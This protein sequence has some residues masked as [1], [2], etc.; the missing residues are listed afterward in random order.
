M[1][2]RTPCPRRG[3]VNSAHSVFAISESM[4]NV[5]SSGISRSGVYAIV[6]SR[7]SPAFNGVVSAL[8]ILYTKPNRV[9]ISFSVISFLLSFLSCT[10]ISL[11]VPK[12]TLPKFTG[13]GLSASLSTTY[14]TL[15]IV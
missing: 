11:V 15:S 6:I 5:F 4:S 8:M 7:L 13:S 9:L 3:H 12:R 2:G 14:F 10:F 1:Q